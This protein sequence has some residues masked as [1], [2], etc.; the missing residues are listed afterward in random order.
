MAEF[1]R[2][3]LLNLLAGAAYFVSGWLG[4]LLATPPSQASPIWPAAGIA[5][6]LVLAFGRRILSGLFLGILITQLYAFSDLDDWPHFLRSLRVG[7]VVALGASLQAWLGAWLVERW[8]GKHDA[9]IEDGKIMR[10]FMA[11]ILSCT[12]S[13]SVGIAMLWSQGAIDAPDIAMGL[14]VWWV[15]DMIG[16]MIFTPLTLVFVGKPRALWRMRQRVVTYPLLA[17]VVL[18]LVAFDYARNQEQQ[19]IHEQ[20]SRQVAL[21]H[22]AIEQRLTG[23]L[24]DNAALQAFFNSGAP[25]TRETFQQFARSIRKD[26]NVVLQWTPRITDAQ[27][28]DW[29]RRNQAT[30][31]QMQAPGVTVVAERR[32]V[33]FPVTYIDPENGNQAAI[34]FDV[35]SNPDIAGPVHAAIDT[36]EARA[37][38]G[39]RLIQDSATETGVVIYAPVY[40]RVVGTW[41]VGQRREAFVGFA[42]TVFRIGRDMAAIFD[43]IGREQAQLEIEIY[44]DDQIIYRSA[45]NGAAKKLDYVGL[46]ES[47]NIDV[48]GCTWRIR[49]QPAPEFFN[50]Q[51]SAVTTWALLSGFLLCGLTGC[52]LLLLTGRTARVGELVAIRTEEIRRTNNALSHE[53]AIRKQQEHELRIAATTFESHEAIVVTDANGTILRVNHAFT[54]ITGYSADEAMGNNP[55]F[56]ASGYHDQAFYAQ[57]YQ[58]LE[59]D[60]R[61]LG[62]IWNRRKNGEVYPERLTL[63]GVRDADGQLTHYV[64]IFSDVSDKKAAEQEIHNLAFYDPL[65]NLP[66]RRLLLDRLHH[67]IAAA[68]RQKCLG[69]LLFLDLDHFKNINDSRG[70]HVGDDLLIQVANRLR[71]IIREEDTAC[72]LGGDEFIVM[73]PAC[74]TISNR[75]RIMLSCWPKKSCWPSTGPSSLA[76]TSTIFRPASALR[77]TRTLLKTR[78]P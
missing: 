20:F 70:H 78:W 53:I 34:G 27:R 42:A 35:V 23:Y 31:K 2:H 12:V 13:G 50:R 55:R 17:A 51:Q 28:S 49:Y 67:E 40:R 44:D 16:A 15:G 56:L 30:I 63:T 54:Q 47:R 64:G 4:F 39:I 71:A 48:A 41:D 61:W 21:L 62:E 10:F 11:A 65:T 33:Y 3:L 36:G 32:A 24:A 5:L 66:N 18:V 19:R 7:A 25:I 52:G 76:M 58:A 45:A 69:C 22:G 29:E 1:F 46:F 26:K 68:K 59:R 60:G 77:C 14:A 43:W 75:R 57:M 6:G 74:L 37:T 38:G 8:V 73:A 72:R 9:L